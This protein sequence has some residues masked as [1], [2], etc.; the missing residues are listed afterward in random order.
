MKMRTLTLK[1][2]GH[3]TISLPGRGRERGKN[4]GE[5]KKGIRETSNS[6]TEVDREEKKR[7][8]RSRN[9][10]EGGRGE[11]GERGDRECG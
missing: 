5:G 4:E 9:S 8:K 2:E 7:E 10:M 1:T 3:K 11:R 6:E